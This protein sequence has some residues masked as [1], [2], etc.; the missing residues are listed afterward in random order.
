MSIIMPS[1]VVLYMSYYIK[2]S[3]LRKEKKNKSGIAEY[4]KSI[5]KRFYRRLLLPSENPD[6]NSL[7]LFP[8][9]G[10]DT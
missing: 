5:Y 8:S 10:A 3:Y 9:S 4:I 2:K 6:R 1:A 7:F